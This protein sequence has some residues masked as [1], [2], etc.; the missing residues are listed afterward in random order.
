MSLNIRTSLGNQSAR[1]ALRVMAAAACA[2]GLLCATLASAQ[3]VSGNAANPIGAPASIVRSLYDYHQLE[4]VTDSIKDF[5]DDNSNLPGSVTP[6]LLGPPQA[7]A[8][9]RAWLETERNRPLLAGLRSAPRLQ[10]ADRLAA[11]GALFLAQNR[12]VEAFACF[13]LANER[14]PKEPAPLIGLAS[15]VLMFRKANEAIALL[16]EA[17]TLGP[18]PP[19]AWGMAGTN[20][21]DYLRGYALM[22]RG[23]Y[24]EA[25]GLLSAVVAREPNLSE[26]ALTLAIVEAKLGEAPRKAFLLGVWRQRPPLMVVDTK[27][28]RAGD[29][30][31]ALDPMSEG[32]VVRPVPSSVFDLS[33]GQPGTLPDVE[34]PKDVQALFASVSPFTEAMLKAQE[35]AAQLGNTVVGPSLAAFEASTAPAAYKRRVEGVYHLAVLRMHALPELDAAAAETDRLRAQLDKLTEDDRKH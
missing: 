18:A 26:A 19:G 10:T 13:Y 11:A 9:I 29:K 17:R 1:P 8:N 28:G 32:E 27:D 5:L 21:V 30:E 22:L 7:H 20:V 25:K 23:E 12:R 16:E 33:R 24:A 31:P 6:S 35:A 4:N 14:A 3:V 15:A 2:A 34:I